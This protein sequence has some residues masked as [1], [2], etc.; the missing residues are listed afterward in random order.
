MTGLLRPSPLEWAGGEPA[1][2]TGSRFLL[3]SAVQK[4]THNRDHIQVS[5]LC[6]LSGFFALGDLNR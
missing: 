1:D 2:E 4:A 5:K 3:L 6:K